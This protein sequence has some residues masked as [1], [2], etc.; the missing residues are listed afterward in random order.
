VTNAI[1]WQRAKTMQN[2]EREKNGKPPRYAQGGAVAR[3][4]SGGKVGKPR[5]W[6]VGLGMAAGGL[7]PGYAAGGMIE[8]M[9]CNG[10]GVCKPRVYV[11]PNSPAQRNADKAAG[12]ANLK[13]QAASQAQ[14]QESRDAQKARMKANGSWGQSWEGQREAAAKPTGG[15]YASPTMKM[16]AGGYVP[17]Y[18][19]G[20]M[21]E[22]DVMLGLAGP[23]MGAVQSASMGGMGG[24]GMD[25]LEAEYA[26]YVQGAEEMGLPPMPFEEYVQLA[27]QT[28]EGEDMMGGMGGGDPHVGGKMVIDPDPNAPTD[29]IPAM[30]DG[31]HPAALDSGEFVIPRH[32]VLFHGIDKL[33][34][35][36]AQSEAAE[37]QM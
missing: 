23:Q 19:D 21:I 24:M 25:P 37:A 20:G 10:Q 3:F 17:G 33:K 29:S 34:K 9:V 5:A 1:L 31:E 2:A 6:S 8:D 35:L 32:A 7:V 26:E 30:I 11:Y 4:S 28:P 22:D 14:M 15:N 12:E 27:Q 16:A 18:A 36:I 13:M